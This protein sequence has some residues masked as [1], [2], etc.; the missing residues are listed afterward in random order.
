MNELIWVGNTH[1]YIEPERK[2]FVQT[3]QSMEIATSSGSSSA[4]RGYVNLEISWP[5]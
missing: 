1:T 2:D 4:C 3:T 5:K